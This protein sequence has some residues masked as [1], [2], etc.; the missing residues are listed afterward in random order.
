MRKL[1]QQ[2]KQI[3]KSA[4]DALRLAFRGS[5]KVTK[6][7]SAIQFSQ[8]T[9]LSGEVLQDIEL[10]QHFG[11]TSVPPENTEAVILPMGGET[12]HSVVI[13]T[14]HGSF[15]VKGLKNG[16]V[17]VYDKSG[18]T[19]ILKEGRVIEVDCDTF[20]VNCKNYEVTALSQAKFFT[21]TLET[22]QVFTAQGQINGNSGMAVQGG[23]GASFSGPVQ[24]KDG[25]F[26]T[27]G[28]VKAGSVSLKT[29]KH[30]EQ[31]DGKPT[32]SPL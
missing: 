6:T 3:G 17:A 10:M 22:S 12:T 26:S 11:F 23:N 19:I 16:E 7:Q 13:A 9:G 27:T 31:G 20:K 1:T 28:D 24:Q 14:E 25:S 8:A 5:L 30:N 2:L 21:P 4:T 29:H 18:S 32:S 15:R